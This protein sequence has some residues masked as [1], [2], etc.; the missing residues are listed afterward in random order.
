MRKNGRKSN[1]AY[2]FLEVFLVLSIFGVLLA[3]V[4]SF[5]IKR[6]SEVNSMQYQQVCFIEFYEKCSSVLRKALRISF[7][8]D[9]LNLTLRDSK[10]NRLRLVF[11]HNVKNSER[12]G[13][14]IYCMLPVGIRTEWY[15]TSEAS[16]WE[17][18]I[19]KKEYTNLRFL[20]VVLKNTKDEI[21]E[22]FIFSCYTMKESSEGK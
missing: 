6:L 9:A 18:L 19:P 12:R 22:Q 20:K 1:L 11:V 5:P 3:L 17:K 16:E 4:L 10:N 21:L 2:T 8:V 15:G 14:Q 13:T 7:E